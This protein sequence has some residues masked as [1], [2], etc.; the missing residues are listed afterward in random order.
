M[1]INKIEAKKIYS[2]LYQDWYWVTRGG[3]VY[4]MYNEKLSKMSPFITKDN[5]VEYVLTTKT[6]TKKHEQAQLIVMKTFKSNTKPGTWQ[7]NHK[8]GNRRNNK[9]SNLEWVTPSQN[10]RHSFDVLGKKIHNLG[11]KRQPDGSYK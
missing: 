5:Y 3:E 1:L 11:K 8:D 4:K 10:I 6:N 7:V 9:L 2:G